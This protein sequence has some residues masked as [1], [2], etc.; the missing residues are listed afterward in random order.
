M[1]PSLTKV[2]LTNLKNK[3]ITDQ[4]R[5]RASVH[6]LDWLACCS[7]GRLSAAGDVY[8][9]YI[10]DEADQSEQPCNVVFG[11]KCYWQ[12]ALLMNSALGNVLEM[13]DIHRSSILHPGPVVIPAALAIAQKHGLPMRNLLN[14][15]VLGY[16]ITI[17][18]G[19]AIGRSHYQYFHN[20]ATCAAMGASLAVSHLLSLTIEQTLA[21]LGNVGSRTSG[22]WQMRNEQ[23]LTKQ[24]HN[25]DAA[26]TGTMA[27]ILA[28]KGLTG[29]EYILEGPQGIF[30]ALSD[31]AMPEKFIKAYDT[32]RIFDCSFKPWPACRHAHSAIDVVLTA[33]NN[34]PRAITVNDVQSVAIFTYQDAL[35]FCDK[36]TPETEL[37]AK[38]SIQHAV[39]AVLTWGQPQLTHYYLEQLHELAHTRSI[40]KVFESPE[41]EGNYP[42]HYGARC[43]ITLHSGEVITEEIIDTLGDPERPLSLEQIKAKASML[44]TAA[45]LSPNRIDELINMTWANDTSLS[46]LNTLISAEKTHGH[47][48]KNK[49]RE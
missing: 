29:P 1:E 21:A 12:D 30:K 44:M 19:K 20:T 10:D 9:A 41:L 6:L 22:L 18:L 28:S 47:N 4:D 45:G 31:D 38:F 40:I 27:A 43:E 32:W 8:Q 23:V 49:T 17:R 37:Q 11:D 15:I 13:D 7:L 3:A 48:E 24:W 26:K 42:A 25:S 14:A 36:P 46:L 2:L 39:A 33:L 16:E 34:I 5:K 35:V